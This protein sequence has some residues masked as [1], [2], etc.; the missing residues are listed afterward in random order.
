MYNNVYI[1][2]SSLKDGENGETGDL[3]RKVEISIVINLL[4]EMRV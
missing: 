1:Y 3:R 4:K 2:T